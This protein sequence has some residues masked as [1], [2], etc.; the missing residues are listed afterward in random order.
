MTGPLPVVELSDAMEGWER[1]G[2]DAWRGDRSG[3]WWGDRSGE[4][5][6]DRTGDGWISCQQ[7]C[8]AT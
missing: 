4:W 7:V 5:W 6:G 1:S 3:E 8:T 2:W